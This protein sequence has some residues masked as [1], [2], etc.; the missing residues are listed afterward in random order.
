[1]ENICASLRLGEAMCCKT[2]ART[3]NSCSSLSQELIC[4][5]PC[6]QWVPHLVVRGVMVI[7]EPLVYESELQHS[8]NTPV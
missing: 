1:M 6:R 2:S 4:I 5:R 7:S 3:H 8:G